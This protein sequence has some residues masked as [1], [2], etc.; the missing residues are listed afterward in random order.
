MQTLLAQHQHEEQREAHR[1]AELQQQRAER[2]EEAALAVA[3]TPL[4]ERPEH[5]HVDTQQCVA[6]QRVGQRSRHRRRGEEEQIRH[7]E[8]QHRVEERRAE[9]IR[10]HVPPKLLRAQIAEPRHHEDAEIALDSRLRATPTLS[11]R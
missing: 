8:H 6:P 4:E 7:E 1:V 2:A 10:V 3:Q 5:P 9:D 11:S